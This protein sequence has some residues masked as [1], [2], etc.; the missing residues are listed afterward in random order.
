MGS[1]GGTLGQHPEN[2]V[3]LTKTT[4]TSTWAASCAFTPPSFQSQGG[5]MKSTWV[6]PQR[7]TLAVLHR[8]ISVP[9]QPM[10]ACPSDL[11]PS[12]LLRNRA[13]SLPEDFLERRLNLRLRI[14][15]DAWHP[16]QS[17]Y[18]EVKHTQTQHQ[19]VTTILSN[20]QN[21]YML[22]VPILDKGT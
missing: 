14:S 12:K 16:F 6:H 20:G 4:P 19:G 8:S 10:R 3:W 15:P 18:V 17:S 11:P 7:R 21:W 5:I 1:A 22:P 13:A 2:H 9:R